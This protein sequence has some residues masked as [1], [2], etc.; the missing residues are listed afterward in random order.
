MI[1]SHKYKFIFIAVPKTGTTSI[2][3]KLDPLNEVFQLSSEAMDRGSSNIK[4][5]TLENLKAH[6]NK[7]LDSYFSFAFCRN[8]WDRHLSIYKFY[9][10]SIKEWEKNT[11]PQ[12]ADHYQRY[13]NLVGGFESFN[14][15]VKSRPGWTE[16]QT[17]W[18]SKNIDFI[19][20]MEN[21]QS[22]FNIIYDKI[23][24]QNCPPEEKDQIQLDHLNKSNRED[25]REVYNN[26]S[27]D[28]IAK[29]YKKD[30]DYLGYKFEA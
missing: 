7:N 23:A 30:I 26:E 29:A 16:L 6:T 3:A 27:I 19:G 21:I 15:F 13:T 20:R 2:E 9:K 11:P 4:H 12:W 28:I 5:I 10:K 14:D 17:H 25:Y 8:P 22:D 24:K 1:I 18:L